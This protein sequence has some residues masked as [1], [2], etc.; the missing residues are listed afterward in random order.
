M[1]IAN[2][3]V[4]SLLAV[5]GL[6][7]FFTTFLTIDFHS[8][9]DQSPVHNGHEFFH[10]PRKPGSGSDPVTRT[11]D[12]M[13]GRIKSFRDRNS[14]STADNHN[15]SSFLS[16]RSNSHINNQSALNVKS[17]FTKTATDTRCK[18]TFEPK[19]RI[20]PL[21]KYWDEV[22]E[23]YTSPL[24]D[25]IGL[26][27]PVEDQKFVV[28]QAD[29]GG[30][31]NIRMALEVVIL[32]AQVL[33]AILTYFLFFIFVQIALTIIMLEPDIELLLLIQHYSYCACFFFFSTSPHQVTGRILVLPPNAVLYLL[34][35]NK[36]WGDNKSSMEDYFDFDK[37]RAFR[38]LQ[39]MPMNA[40]LATIAKNGLLNT[41]LPNNDTELLRKPLWD[42]LNT[43]CYVRPWS[44]G[45]L[46][47]GFNI[48]SVTDGRVTDKKVNQ[49]SLIGDF[50][51]T[52]PSRMEAF[53]LQSK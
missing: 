40:F 9:N 18:V 23:C 4:F 46:Y 19:C 2:C 43:A 21:V 3:Q 15:Q 26:D 34:H 24:R 6:L 47:I 25:L 30:W 16:N 1:Q 7:M 31:N 52:D 42:Y 20:N 41:P 37:L 49:N 53:A 5:V 28:F 14:V 36:K 50:Q 12:A 33:Y 11:V 10:E 38:G 13:I 8:S 29:A 39:T 22:M 44:P 17:G 45:K 48:S 51:R 35:M 27:A 32:F